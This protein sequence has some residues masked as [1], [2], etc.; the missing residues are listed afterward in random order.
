MNWQN[1][2]PNV[3]DAGT[4]QALK[5]APDAPSFSLGID[6]SPT[7]ADSFTTSDIE[8]LGEILAESDR[9]A[10]EKRTLN[11]VPLVRKQ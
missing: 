4:T 9:I 11:R 7:K 8:K 10:L 5:D 3:P 2:E 6:N 1:E